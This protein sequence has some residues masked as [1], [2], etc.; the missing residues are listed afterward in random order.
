MPEVLHVQR[1]HHSGNESGDDDEGER[2]R[3]EVELEGLDPENNPLRDLPQ[4]MV[5]YPPLI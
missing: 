1:R 2:E 3:L 4:P 5:Q